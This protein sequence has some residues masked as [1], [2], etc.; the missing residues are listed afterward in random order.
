ML[1]KKKKVLVQ[2]VRIVHPQDW[3]SGKIGYV[4]ETIDQHSLCTYVVKFKGV[5][6]VRAYQ[7]HDIK[8]LAPAFVPPLFKLRKN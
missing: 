3:F 7:R 4:I 8:F 2:R 5:E 1:V 6:D